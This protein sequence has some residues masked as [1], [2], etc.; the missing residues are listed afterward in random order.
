[1]AT[2]SGYVRGI[3]ALCLGTAVFVPVASLGQQED[4]G[5]LVVGVR[6]GEQLRYEDDETTARTD[7]GLSVNAQTRSQSLRFNL[8]TALDKSF[9]GGSDFDTEDPR[10]NLGYT[11]TNISSELDVTLSYR[12]VD[13]DDAEVNL[14]NG[15]I[16]VID[17]GEREDVRA[18]LRMTLGRNAP[19]GTTVSL[20]YAETNFIS[21]DPD[22]TDSETLR[23]SVGFRANL[24]PTTTGFLTFSGSE[25]DR[26]GGTDVTNTG[27]TAELQ[28]QASSVLQTNFGLGF[29]RVVSETDTSRTVESGA[30]FGLGGTL[31]RQN[32]TLD[33]QLSSQIVENGRRTTLRVNRALTLPRG[34]LRAGIGLSYN[35]DTDSTDPL[36]DLSYSHTLPRS[37]FNTSL[38]QRV[39][40]STD[41]TETLASQLRIS[42]DH[43]L[44]EISSLSA[45]FR[46]RD[47]NQLA[48][49][50]T[51]SRQ[52]GISVSYGRQLTEQWRLVGAYSHTR[53]ERDGESDTTDNVLSLGIRSEFSWRP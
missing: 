10:Y 28:V 26:D 3:A 53:R 4:A 46:V 29:N 23:G 19:F 44:S 14:E 34:S 5:G 49:S 20:N 24:T 48:A 18:G 12:K 36:Y 27:L 9:S 38:N 13:T 33:A 2:T 39:T 16:L 6:V 52:Y 15:D 42:M 11:R 7:L 32:G 22:L 51:D 17:D 31:E 43:E 30:N 37:T 21:G 8:D 50:G 41:G 45:S 25:L 35:S 47:T 40:T 1:M